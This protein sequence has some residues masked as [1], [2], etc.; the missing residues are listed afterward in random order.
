MDSADYFYDPAAD[1]Q[2][3]KRKRRLA[4]LMRAQAM[5][6]GPALHDAGAFK[7][8]NWGDAI[9]R[10]GTAWAA[11]NADK[12]LKADEDKTTRAQNAYTSRKTDEYNKLRNGVPTYFGD[13]TR[14]LD[15]TGGDTP[16]PVVANAG[17]DRIRAL[18]MA[19]Q[20]RVPALVKQAKEDRAEDLK[21]LTVPGASLESR[22]D[23]VAGMDAGGLR[24]EPKEHVV[25]GQVFVNGQRTLD[26]RSKFDPPGPIAGVPGAVGQTEQETGKVNRLSPAPG[27]TVNVGEKQFIKEHLTTAKENQV[28]ARE[29]Q[30]RLEVNKQALGLIDNSITGL[31]ANQ[32]L[33]F[34]RL[35][36]TLGLSDDEAGQV[37][38]SQGLRKALA[39]NVLKTL[40]ALRPASNVDLEWTK[41]VELADLTADPRAMKRAIRIIAAAD[42]TRQ[43]QARQDYAAILQANQGNEMGFSP[44]K[45]PDIS[46]PGDFALRFDE[47]RG[48]FTL[49]EKE[50]PPVVGKRRGETTSPTSVMESGW[51]P[52]K[53]K[54][55]QEL[56]K[57]HGVQP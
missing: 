45:P 54:R 36:K 32:I 8:A 7:V 35:A 33:D 3:L 47:G 49:D 51:S 13:D 34:K 20:S 21:F 55:L 42:A 28:A 41:A 15:E 23:A 37:R 16:D 53:E 44:Y 27:T 43:Y 24:P 56:R 39:P 40:Q 11:G 9:A 46:V 31:G 57:K 18:A 25:N 6:K 30:Q 4:E 19:M 38:D 14:G 17:K 48:M 1:D 5:I 12:E 29:S 52:D 50:P 26:A 2:R 22:R 10:M